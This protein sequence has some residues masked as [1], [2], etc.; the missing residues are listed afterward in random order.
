MPGVELSAIGLVTGWGDGVAALP[1][2]AARRRGIV[3]D[4]RRHA[5]VGIPVTM[6][7]LAITAAWF[8]LRS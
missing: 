5:S 6:A 1:D 7:T 2:D 8:G 3:I 4:W